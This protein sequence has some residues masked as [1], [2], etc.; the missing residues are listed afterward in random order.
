MPTAEVSTSR[1]V[2]RRTPTQQRNRA[3]V[4]RILTVA[5]AL[6]V[7]VGYEAAVRSHQELLERAKVTRGTFYDY[8]ENC[9]AVMEQLSLDWLQDCK[10]IIDEVCA[11]PHSSWQAAMDAIIDAFVA[12]YRTPSVQELWLHHHITEAALDFEAET[13]RYIAERTADLIKRTSGGRMRRSPLRYQ[14]ASELGDR[15][16]RLAFE[17]NPDG[18]PLVINEVKIAYRSYISAPEAPTS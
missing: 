4:E 6:L 15:V 16:L 8:F 12:F 9:E 5:E 10:R 11:A 14:V 18:D 3:A 1:S 2:L 17:R 7:E 13:N